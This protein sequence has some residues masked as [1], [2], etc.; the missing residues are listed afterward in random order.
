MSTATQSPIQEAAEAWQRRLEAD[1]ANAQLTFTTKGSSTGIVATDL[2]AGRHEW[3]IDEPAALA[4]EDTGTSPAEA[5]LGALAAC[6][7][8]VYRLYAQQLGIVVDDI[9][10]DARGELDVRGLLGAA[11]DVR[12][13]FSRVQLDVTVHGPESPERYAELQ[14]IVDARCPILDVFRNPVPVDVNL[15]S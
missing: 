11:E 3:R 13:G 9:D 6:Q 7:V 5:A 1:P 8:V 12:S 4:G 10:I 2:K 15:K 14:A